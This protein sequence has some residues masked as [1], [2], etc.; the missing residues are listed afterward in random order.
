MARKSKIDSTPI[1]GVFPDPK[2][3]GAPYRVVFRYIDRTGKTKQSSKRNFATVQEAN[4]FCRAKEREREKAQTPIDDQITLTEYLD[5]WKERYVLTRLKPSTID[6]Y[7]NCIRIIQENLG[8][9]RLCKL[10]HSTINS[11]YLNL[12]RPAPGNISAKPRALNSIRYVKRVLHK[13]LEDAVLEKV[14][15]ENPSR[16]VKLSGKSKTI[17]QTLTKPEISLIRNAV[18]GTALYLPVSL[19]V[20]LGLRRAEALGL[21]WKDINFESGIISIRQTLV[22]TSAGP[23]IQTPKTQTSFRDI[24]MPAQLK[25]LLLEEKERQESNR[26][27][28]GKDYHENDL[29]CCKENGDA[30]SPNYITHRFSKVIDE[31][32]LTKVR[33]H[34]LRH[35]YATIAL[36]NNV[37]L[38]VVSSFLGHSNIAVTANTYS[39]VTEPLARQ[40]SNTI[41]A[42][43]LD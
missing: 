3:G 31:L 17:Y 15:R 8:Q 34:D 20:S 28:L 1:P 16:G 10:D 43:I 26:S 42:A 33:F 29:V 41:A 4:E 23:I 5:I 22:M 24:T 2:T 38:K 9:L 27:L 18:Q 11:F 35:T 32:S 40:H 30:Y 14:I 12:Q 21:R 36:E 13:A 6:G 7:R 39:H 19:S 25:A 37:P